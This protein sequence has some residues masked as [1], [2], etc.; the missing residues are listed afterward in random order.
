MHAH[1][2]CFARLLQGRLVLPL[3]V[4][5]RAR[6]GRDGAAIFSLLSLRKSKFF[7]PAGVK[8]SCWPR[9]GSSSP[10]K[11]ISLC[12]LIPKVS[13]MLAT[14]RRCARLFSGSGSGSGVCGFSFRGELGWLLNHQHV[15]HREMVRAAAEAD[16][17]RKPAL[18][19][20]V[21]SLFLQK[22]MEILWKK[23]KAISYFWRESNGS[24]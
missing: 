6:R 3:R 12:F 16:R 19:P 23:K 9:L 2:I 7:Q 13:G 14:R 1:F 22:K 18:L 21:E 5:E 11:C 10:L 17:S 24:F 4:E 20:S 8:T 15:K